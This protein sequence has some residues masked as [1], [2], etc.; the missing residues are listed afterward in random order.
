MLRVTIVGDVQKVA[1]E[2]IAQLG[3]SGT[4]AEQLY[5]LSLAI[6]RRRLIPALEETFATRVSRAL[7]GRGLAAMVEIRAFRYRRNAEGEIVEL[8]SQ[9]VGPNAERVRVDRIEA[10]W[11]AYLQDAFAHYLNENITWL[12]EIVRGQRRSE[13]DW[14]W[15]V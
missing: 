5:R 2:T 6:F 4:E 14:D 10:S 15:L 8:R 3:F 7:N 9:A 1:R 11:N 12:I 13:P